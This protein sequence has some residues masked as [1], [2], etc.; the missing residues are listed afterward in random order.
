MSKY[1][2]LSRRPAHTATDT[3]EGHRAG[4]YM[5]W[6]AHNAGKAVSATALTA[7]TRERWA[8]LAESGQVTDALRDNSALLQAGNGVEAGTVR[9]WDNGGHKARKARQGLVSDTRSAI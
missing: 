1:A 3:R 9:R 4:V 2:K 6:Q 8:R 5:T 7:E